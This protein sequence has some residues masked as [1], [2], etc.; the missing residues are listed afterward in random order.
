MPKIGFGEVGTGRKLKYAF[1]E[2][3]CSAAFWYSTAW[4][5][6]RRRC[7]FV[8]PFLTTLPLEMGGKKR[9]ECA[10]ANV[11]G[12]NGRRSRNHSAAA[13]LSWI[14]SSVASHSEMHIFNVS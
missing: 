11:N 3:P 6:H 13:V 10:D 4:Q 5:Q 2:T 1:C 12:R 14:S 9:D 8:P 7:N